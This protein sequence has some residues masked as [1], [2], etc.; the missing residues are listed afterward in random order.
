[1][2][3]AIDQGTDA[4]LSD[5]A[6]KADDETAEKR[7]R[8]DVG[9]GT[10]EAHDASHDGRTSLS[11]EHSFSHLYD[12]DSLMDEPSPRVHFNNDNIEE[13]WY[14]SGTQRRYKKM[15][16]TNG[17]WRDRGSIE[18]DIR[19]GM[20]QVISGKD[21]EDADDEDRKEIKDKHRKILKNGKYEGESTEQ[22]LDRLLITLDR[23]RCVHGFGGTLHPRAHNPAMELLNSSFYNP[24]KR[25]IG[26]V[27]KRR[28]ISATQIL[29]EAILACV[30]FGNMDL[31]PQLISFNASIDQQVRGSAAN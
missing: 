8:I 16:V 26:F 27:D 2:G 6:E 9:S 25:N 4:A 22:A 12:L 31:I 13:A 20:L 7:P 14:C 28:A 24:Y 19:L 21:D 3:D 17:V 11:S 1:M 30:D 10:D 29:G 23:W 5:S 18:D 15:L